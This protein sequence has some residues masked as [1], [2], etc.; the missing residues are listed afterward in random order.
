MPHQQEIVVKYWSWCWKWYIPTGYPCRKSKTVMGWCYDFAAVK[1]YS[2]GV[3]CKGVGC[4]PDIE[5]GQAG[6]IEYTKWQWCLGFGS[7][8]VYNVTLCSEDAWDVSGTCS[9]Y[10]GQ[11]AG[12][13]VQAGENVTD[14]WF[15]RLDPGFE[16]GTYARPHPGGVKVVETFGIGQYVKCQR[17]DV[18]SWDIRADAYIM[19]GVGGADTPMQWAWTLGGTS[20]GQGTFANDRSS[21][22][23]VTVPSSGN[24]VPL[25]VTATDS[26]GRAVTKQAALN[27]SSNQVFCD[28]TILAAKKPLRIPRERIS[29]DK[30]S[31]A[32]LLHDTGV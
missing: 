17:Y 14:P 25:Q 5:G 22:L 13:L 7:K 31:P 28:Q 27:L 32:R 9:P 18:A 24:Q 23:A 12:P 26:D 2:W 6:G 30:V 21:V 4:E 16:D 1:E 20:H 29:P 15:L 8:T 19:A 11:N 3:R 10:T